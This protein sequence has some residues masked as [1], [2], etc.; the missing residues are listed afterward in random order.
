MIGNLDGSHMAPDISSTLR[1][2]G[3]VLHLA[4]A[5]LKACQT[6]NV[7]RPN[8]IKH[9]LVTKHADVEVSS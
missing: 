1:M 4:R 6:G 5:H 9:C 7:W 3:H 2:K 8:I